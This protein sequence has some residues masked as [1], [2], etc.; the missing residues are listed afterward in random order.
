[1]DR[2]VFQTSFILGFVLCLAKGQD[3][4]DGYSHENDSDF[5]YGVLGQNITLSCEL[6]AHCVR[7]LW[8]FRTSPVKYLNAGSCSNCVESFSVS[9]IIHGD[10][11]YSSLH[12]INI[13]ERLAGIYDCNCQHENGAD[14]VKC[15]N[16]QIESASC[17]L[18]LTQNEEVKVFDNNSGSQH[19]EAVRTVNVNTDDIITARC[20]SDSAKLKNNCTNRSWFFKI[21]E[22]K[23]RCR[24][25]CIINNLCEA[26]IILSVIS[27]T[28]NSPST[29]TTKEEV[30]RSTK[31]TITKS[32]TVTFATSP[33][34]PDRNSSLTSTI[35]GVTR[36]TKPTLTKNGTV[37]FA[38]SPYT[39]DRNSLSTSMMKNKS[40]KK[41]TD[42]MTGI[43]V[44]I[45]V[46]IT[47]V[48]VLI[49]TSISLFWLVSR[50]HSKK[51][52]H[53]YSTDIPLFTAA[54]DETKYSKS[55][56]PSTMDKSDIEYARHIYPSILDNS[57]IEYE[58]HIHNLVPLY[59]E[60]K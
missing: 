30:T 14:K 34:T 49:L 31:L 20:V 48:L 1:M 44:G 53:E 22:S 45:T 4:C 56:Y 47:L 28:T 5:V 60:I 36:S 6:Q 13:N 8:A 26:R 7:G 39:T 27:S 35:K 25:S 32:S 57:D 33:Y 59:D 42:N 29:S 9:D 46:L 12:I 41:V 52:E 58:R 55:I 2:S 50:K 51:V 10:I 24:I 11:M 17:Q 23:D 54:T 18:E 43:L 19:N 3:T 21:K 38:T 40:G 15:F 37:N 16:L